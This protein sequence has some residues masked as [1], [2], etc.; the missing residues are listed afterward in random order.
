MEAIREFFVINHTIVLFVYGLTFFAMGLVIF[1][2]SRRHS[3]LR[4]SRDLQ[5]LAAFGILH[6]IREWGALFVP[7]QASYMPQAAIDALETVQVILLAASFVCLLMFG[8]ATL[9]ERHPWLKKLVIVLGSAWSIG[10]IVTLYGLPT[11]ESSHLFSSI[12]A[13]YL[14]ALPGSLLAA[15]GLRYQAKTSIAPLNIRRI[16]QMLRVAGA[17]LLAYAFFAGMIVP[18]ADFF[19]ANTFNYG[20]LHSTIGIPVQVIRSMIGLVLAITIIRALEIFEIEVDRLIE[21]MEVE[22]IQDDERER[23]GQEIHDGA[24]Q[25]VY[26][27][28]LILE[29]MDSLVEDG[30]ELARRLQQA[31]NVLNAVNMD[32]RR[33]M[34]SLRAESPSDPLIPSLRDLV[35]DPRFQG[36]LHVD[37]EYNV[38]PILKPIQ[39]YHIVAIVQEGLSNTLR[40]A[41]AHRAKISI[42]QVN[43]STCVDI[44]DDG[45]GFLPQTTPASYGLRSMRDRARLIGGQLVIESTPGK[46]THI[47]L[48]LPEEK[49]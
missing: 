49:T 17:V 10:F 25:G 18:K 1:L 28:G 47:L 42:R 29:S 4:L 2:Q 46:G 11:F 9:E 13:R 31:K 40:H 6:G 8:A 37:L 14:L 3:R 36:L 19:P 22:Q 48:N 43:G 30:S 24:I 12:A 15:Y 41:R 7:I 27:A 35:T 44:E 21:Q 45:R 20:L 5:W 33:Y 39:V 16:Y 34:V 38:E 32:L 26:S 23:I